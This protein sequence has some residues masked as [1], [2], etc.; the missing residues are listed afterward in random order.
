MIIIIFLFNNLYITMLLHQ[1]N[2]GVLS[3]KAKTPGRFS[4]AND[5]GNAYNY[6]LASS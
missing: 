3:D 6:Y 5:V 1:G 2:P 4:G